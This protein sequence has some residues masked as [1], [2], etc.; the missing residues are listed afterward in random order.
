MLGEEDFI[1]G[2]EGYVRMGMERVKIGGN[3]VQLCTGL[4]L[5]T[6]LKI[7][8]DDDNKKCV[9]NSSTLTRLT[10]GVL[11]LSNNNN[12]NNKTSATA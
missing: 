2:K 1:A 10:Y 3:A 9:C 4:P 8:Q 5:P 7:R 12:T 11:K 6:Q